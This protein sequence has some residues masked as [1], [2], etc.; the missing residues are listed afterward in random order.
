MTEEKN[1]INTQETDLPDIKEKISNL[2]I[3]SPLSGIE[4]AL[5]TAKGIDNLVQT[6]INEL[7]NKYGIKETYKQA[8]SYAGKLAEVPI[9]ALASPT[10]GLAATF[11]VGIGAISG[12]DYKL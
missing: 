10:L 7:S 3:L 12:A 8:L 9:I 6:K 11:V 1:I 4:A 2:F 5:M